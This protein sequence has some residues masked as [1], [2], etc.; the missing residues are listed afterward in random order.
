MP[1]TG[2]KPTVSELLETAL[3]F[4]QEYYIKVRSFAATANAFTRRSVI[5]AVGPF[6]GVLRSGGDGEW[7]ARVGQAGFELRY[8]PDALVD[9]PARANSQEILRK[10]RRTVGGERDRNPGWKDALVFS[11]WKLVPPRASI[12]AAM[13]LEQVPLAERIKVAAFA[14]YLNWVRGAYRMKLQLTSEH[15]V[16]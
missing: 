14:T 6:N 1:M 5:E 12:R 10:L 11:A 15:S 13:R 9:H 16:R 3:A 2:A 4:P 7:G 8:A